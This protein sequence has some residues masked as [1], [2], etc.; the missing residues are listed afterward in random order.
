[1]KY[2]FEHKQVLSLGTLCNAMGISKSGYFAHQNREVSNR[3]QENQKLSSTIHR[4]FLESRASYGCRRIA[5]DLDK[6]GIT[7]SKSKV[8]RLMKMAG[9]RSVHTKK[10]KVVTT[11]SNHDFPVY[12]NILNREFDAEKPNEKWV[13]DITYVATDEG[14]LYVAAMLDLHSRKVIGLAMEDNMR[15]GLCI[16]A[17]AAAYTFRRPLGRVLHHTDRGSQY[18]SDDYQL[19]LKT[20]GLD[21]SMSRVGNCWDNAVAESF[22]KTLKVECIYQHHFKTRQEAKEAINDYIY[23]FYNCKRKHSALD[24]KT[25]L[26]YELC[27]A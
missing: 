13:G 8:A 20:H 4:L 2:I 17:I 10:F 18:A 27:A 16:N 26:E 19:F 12:E 6:M 21:A 15:A 11:D 24:Y 7:C 9:L 5:D 14:W 3:V 25:P 23:N 22:F 1:M